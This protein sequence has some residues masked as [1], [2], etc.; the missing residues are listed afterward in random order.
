MRL[1]RFISNATG[2]SRR[3]VHRQ[4]KSGNV[5]V[6]GIKPKSIGLQLK[7]EQKVKVDGK[8]IVPAQHIYL[9]L[10]KPDGYICANTDEQ[11]STVIDL[12]ESTGI[13]PH[14]T[15]PFQI[16]GRLDINTTGL[17]LLTTDGKWNHK[18]TAPSNQCSKTYIVY[19]AEP[20]SAENISTLESGISLKSEKKPTL[21][22]KISPIDNST[23]KIELNE[24]KYHQVK[25]MFAAV[26][27]KVTKLHRERIGNIS[28]PKDLELGE[29][30]ALTPEQIDTL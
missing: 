9:M 10:H 13:T 1:D 27:N 6:D 24:G 29:F 23:V 2:L 12:L 4:I 28:L 22:C 19:L 20:I 26:G 5:L 17:V 18:I 8:I 11:H 16:V 14:P 7:P 25:R 30:R 21:P 3:L 15:E